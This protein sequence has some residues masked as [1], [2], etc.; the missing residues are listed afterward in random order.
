M[1]KEPRKA[2][3]SESEDGSINEFNSEYFRIISNALFGQKVFNERTGAGCYTA[4]HQNLTVDIS[5]GIPLV[6]FRRT[7]PHVAAAEVMW[8]MMGTKDLSWLQKHTKVW[9]VF[10]DE[11][12]MLD[13]SYG[14][15]WAHE[16]GVDQFSETIRKLK[17]TPGTR[18]AVVM[19]WNPSTDVV[20]KA[21]NVPCPLGFT[22]NIVNGT[23]NLDV[24][25]RSSDLILGFPV[26]FIYFCILNAL[27]A[28]ELDCIPK[29]VSFRLTNAHVY[30][31]HEDIIRPIVF[32]E[33]NYRDIYLPKLTQSLSEALED[34][35]S[36]V[37]EIKS[38]SPRHHI[39]IQL[40]VV[41]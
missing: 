35:D 24:Y 5:N 25:L 4:L 10:A 38:D 29:L 9:D 22:F 40:P 39:N 18:Q 7:W 26:D 23:M 37:E 30:E 32:D 16:F 11:N 8:A 13:A 28:N 31:I 33:R 36:F 34:P 21:K 17:E 12:N 14:Y 41:E 2:T 19:S 1:S 6:G 27:V 15:R 20:T 3:T